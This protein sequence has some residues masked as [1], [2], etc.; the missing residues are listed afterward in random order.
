MEIKD[1]SKI[2][3]LFDYIQTIKPAMALTLQLAFKNAKI[4]NFMSGTRLVNR[5]PH[6]YSMW[7]YPTI[8]E[9]IEKGRNM[10]TF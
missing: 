9:Q 6:D 10:R 2:I 7:G 5:I 8:N 1:F 4:Y 3:D